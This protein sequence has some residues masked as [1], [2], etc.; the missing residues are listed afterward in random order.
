VG[1]HALLAGVG[2]EA[3]ATARTA[4][5]TSFQPVSHAHSYVIDTFADLGLIGVALSLALLVSWCLAAAR[6][7]APRTRWRDLVSERVA[8]R[9]GLMALGC[10]VVAFGVQSAVDWTWF[11]TGV[12]VPAL[13]C[14]GWLVGRG[15]LGHPVGRAAHR[16]PLLQ[17]PGSAAALAGL[18]ALALALAWFTWQPLRSADALSAS[19]S[20]AAAGHHPE[21][22]TEARDAATI[23]PVSVAPLQI[24]SSLYAGAGDPAAAR[25]QLIDA[26]HRQSGN[27]QPWQWLGQ[28]ELDHG[29]TRAAYRTL[30]R[31]Q[32][33]DRTDTWTGLLLAKA[34]TQLGIAL[35]KS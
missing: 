25:Q 21:A 34:R 4:Y 33:L 6:P 14:A 29:Q 26:T 2:A 30:L 15:P 23:D 31:A 28:F 19:L 18:T 12:A 20:A 32:R 11:F 16:R 1:E 9:E 17:R 5:A 10:V 8:E 3:F 22:F 35:A 24:L 13:V 27:P 7:L